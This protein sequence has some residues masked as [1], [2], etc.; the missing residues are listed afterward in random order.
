MSKRVNI[1]DLAVGG[2]GVGRLE[3]G[4]IIFVA[5]AAVDDELVVELIEEKKRYTRG[6]IIEVVSAGE[7]RRE[8][9]CR[10]VH[11]GCGGCDW[12]HLSEEAQIEAKI[13]TVRDALIKLGSIEPPEVGY[14]AGPESLRYRTTVRVGIKNGRPAYRRS[15][16]NQLVQVSDCP[17]AHPLMDDIFAEGFFGTANEVTIRVGARTGDRLVMGHPTADEFEL[18]AGV[19]QIG[20]N[21]TRRGASA[22]IIEEVAGVEWQ[23][24]ARSFFQSSPEGAEMLVALVAEWLT[25][26]DSGEQVLV[27]LYSGVGLFS[28]TVGDWFQK[29]IAVESATSAVSDATNN[30]GGHVAIHHMQVEKWVPELADVVIADPPR[31]GLRAQG[32]EIIRKTQ[33]PHV[34][35]VSC[36]AGALGRDAALMASGGYELDQV[37]VLDMFP[38]TSHV[39]VVSGWIRRN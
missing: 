7:G 32:V 16:S 26:Q 14:V 38:Q 23:I 5:G 33:A 13:S 35:L 29:V 15:R 36:D 20:K 31:A 21:Q 19:V 4:R 24:S 9:L 30:L 12:Q 18:P 25:A 6:E 8:P 22:H 27:D 10:H 17:I 37:D 2:E 34:V 3:D 39:E 1:Y 28:G 11:A